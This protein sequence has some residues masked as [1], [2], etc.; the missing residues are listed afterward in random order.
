MMSETE[1][2]IRDINRLLKTKN[3]ILASLQSKMS[4]KALTKE[5]MT[6]EQIASFK[7]FYDYYTDKSSGVDETLAEACAR[8]ASEDVK[9]ENEEFND[10]LNEIHFKLNDIIEYG[11]RTLSFI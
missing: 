7:Q 5:D 10:C 8:L 6:E 2:N 11:M 3:G 9:D 4:I 1:R